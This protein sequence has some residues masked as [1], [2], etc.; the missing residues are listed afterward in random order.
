MLFFKG[1]G[2]QFWTNKK[3]LIYSL[4]CNK[5]NK[6]NENSSYKYWKYTKNDDVNA[7]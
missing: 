7:L 2:K 1:G 3:N 4:C 6:R 5:Y